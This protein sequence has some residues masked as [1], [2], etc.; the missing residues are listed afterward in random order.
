MRSVDDHL[1]DALAAIGP[2]P[3]REL[4]LLD[5]LGCLLAEDVVSEIDLPRFDNSSM[6]G[7]AVRAGELT[8]VGPGA[9][10]SLPVHGDIPAGHA[11]T[12]RLEPG[13]AVRIMTGAPV[14]EGAD[15]VVPVE[16]TDGGTDRVQIRRSPSV[17]A[18]LR[19]CGEDVRAGQTVL[20]VGTRLSSRQI[21]LL[22][23]VG[24]ARVLVQPRPLVL[25]MPSGSELVAP[26][27]PLGPGQ[28]HDS[29]GYGLIAAVRELGLDAE[30]GGVI[31]D[32]ADAVTAALELA[33]RRADLVITTGGVSAGAYDTIKAVLREL[34]TVQ[35]EK[36]AMQP[37][38]PQGFG[39]IGPDRTPIFTL[40]GNPV[41][42]FVSFEIFVRPALLRMAGESV[43]SVR[44]SARTG[45]ASA[46]VGWSSPEGKRQF[47]RARLEE[48]ESLEDGGAP[49]PVVWPVGGQGSHLVSD[50]AEANCLVVVPEPVT[51]VS[52]GD[53]VQYLP[54][55]RGSR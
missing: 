9:P 15:A 31:D 8:E 16:W 35:F 46:A 3:A 11:G 21:A 13:T 23:A 12:V 32:D 22:A 27:K 47:V 28:I 38:M 40:P 42:A 53:E 37:G 6:D 17:G 41:S 49:V 55:E 33:A 10:V 51:R 20:R 44:A 48:L 26:G 39:V 7:Y 36:V 43:A 52:I 50:L 19:H 29:N 5:A 4:A 2:L 45:T 34:G 54:L 24:R 30:H 18:Y 14:P 25:V 1:T